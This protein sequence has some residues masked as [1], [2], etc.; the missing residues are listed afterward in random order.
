MK[1]EGLTEAVGAALLQS[2]TDAIIVADLRGAIR[3]DNDGTTTALIAILHE[4]T[5]PSTPSR[6]TDQR[7]PAKCPTC[8]AERDDQ[9]ASIS[10]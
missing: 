4:R 8:A 5:Q 2:R 1:R 7:R 6:G 9:T 10:Q 3:A